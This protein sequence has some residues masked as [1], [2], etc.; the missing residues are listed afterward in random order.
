MLLDVYVSALVR[1]RLATDVKRI[2]PTHV[3]S[4]LDPD[5]G[6]VD[7][8][9][10]GVTAKHRVLRFH[11][12]LVADRPNGFMVEHLREILAFVDEAIAH[13][14]TAAGRLLV[15]CHFGQSRSPAIAYIALAVALGPGRES[16]AF[17]T[18]RLRCENPWPNRLIVEVADAELDRKG[19]LTRPL[20]DFQQRFKRPSAAREL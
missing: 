20:V 12:H 17:E 2:K 19:Q 3:L 16:E 8:A 4:L 11:D 13:S 7:L 15:H 18:V 1:D 14:K 5:R 10:L 6:A 9:S